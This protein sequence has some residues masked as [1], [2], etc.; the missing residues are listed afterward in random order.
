MWRW[1]ALAVAPRIAHELEV[2]KELLRDAV[3]QNKAYERMIADY[4]QRKGTPM[5]EDNETMSGNVVGGAGRA[6]ETV[7]RQVEGAAVEATEFASDNVLGRLLGYVRAAKAIAEGG[8][9]GALDVEKATTDAI[10]KEL[11]DLSHTTKQ[12]VKDAASG[13]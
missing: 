6:V 9:Q 12:A 2:T 3:N 1:L 13:R 11:D 10:L 8:L 4:L 7:A 5:S